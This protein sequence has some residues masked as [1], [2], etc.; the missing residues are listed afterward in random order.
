MWPYTHLRRQTGRSSA[1]VASGLGLGMAISTTS[2]HTMWHQAIM[3]DTMWH[4]VT[5]HPPEEADRTSFSSWSQRVRLGMARAC[6]RLTS[7]SWTSDVS[8]PSVSVSSMLNSAPSRPDS[9]MLT[10]ERPSLPSPARVKA[11]ALTSLASRVTSCLRQATAAR[12]SNRW[13]LV[14][15]SCENNRHHNDYWVTM[16]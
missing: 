5:L 2:N 15:M 13:E 4:S 12:R 14:R 3:C 16:Q 1:A 7:V 11:M 6:S 8:L 10:E 9:V